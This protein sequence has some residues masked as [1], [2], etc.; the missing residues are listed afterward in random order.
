MPYVIETS[1]GYVKTGK[2]DVKIIEEA[3]QFETL[4]QAVRYATL[5]CD[6]SSFTITEV[7]HTD[8]R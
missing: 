4:K 2:K 1:Q 3:K 5:Y 8:D 6:S 7:G